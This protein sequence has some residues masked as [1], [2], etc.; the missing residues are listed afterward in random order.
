MHAVKRAQIQFGDVCVI[1]GAG[2]LGLGMIA[3]A[4]LKNPGTLVAIDRFDSRLQVARNLGA[5]VT[6]NP[7]TDDV[8]TR[9]LEMTEGYGCDVYI[10]ATGHPD[11]VN[12]GIQM[13]RKGGNFVEFSV[14]AKETSTDW[15]VIGDIKELNLFGA[16]LGP[17][18]YP[19]IID[20]LNRGLVERGRDRHARVAPGAVPRR[21]SP[22][23]RRQGLD[24]SAA[25][26]VA[27]IFRLRAAA[28]A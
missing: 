20:Y 21:H 3:C 4:R 18:C 19:T 5:D 26:A 12:Q 13:I 9:V 23:P 8:I 11:A 1:A 28:V 10:E 17:G 16:H 25:K 27:G 6:L 15:T 7:D 14:M 2:T 24:K 22:G